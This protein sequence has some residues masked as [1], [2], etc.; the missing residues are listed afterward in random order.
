[1]KAVNNRYRLVKRLERGVVSNLYLARDLSKNRRVVLKTIK[2]AGFR[3]EITGY[4]RHSFLQASRLIHANLA[5]D[6]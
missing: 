4:F 1:M 6:L 3:E 2:M 5:P